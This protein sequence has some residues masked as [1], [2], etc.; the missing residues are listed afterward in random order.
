MS[1]RVLLS[2]AAA[3]VLVSG[4]VWEATR[5]GA[6]STADTVKAVT[7][8]RGTVA[9]TVGGIGRITTLSDAARF[10][11]NTDG[12]GS[13]TGSTA[14]R[15]EAVFATTSGHVSSVL[16]VVGDSVMAGQPIAV[17]S[18]D[19][20][21]RST[22]LQARSNLATA[23]LELA[24]KKDQ[25]PARGVPPT[26]AELE[27]SQQAIAAAQDRLA[28]VT[29][30]PLPA[31]LA[32]ARLELAR[33]V[34]DLQIQKSV[35]NARPEALA[36]AD[37]AVQTANQRLALVSGAP[38][39]AQVTAAQLDVAKAQLD[40]E[41]LLATPALAAAAD[42]AAADAAVAAAQEKVTAAQVSGIATD[43]AIAQAELARARADRDTL[44][45]PPALPSAA[46]QAAAALAVNTAQ[47]KLDQLLTPAADVVSAARAELARV[48]AELTTIRSS[49]SR[50]ATAAAKA[51]R[52]AAEARVDLLLNPPV[53]T[54][55]AARSEVRRASADLSVLRQRG[56]PATATDLSISRLR[57]DVAEQQFRLAKEM[58]DR[59]TIR[60]PSVG[61]V[62]SILTAAGSAVD[63]TTPLVRIQDLDNLVV[64]VSLTEFDV[65]KAQVGAMAQVS[66]D[67]LGGR[68]YPGAVLD[69]APSGTD[70][71]GVV[72]FPVIV[73]VGKGEGLRPGMSVSVRVD[74]ARKS[75]VVRVPLD[76]IEERA[77]KAVSVIV[78]TSS[79]DLED[80]DVK[81]GLIGPT[82]AEVRTGLTVGDKVVL[83]AEDAA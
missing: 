24:Q 7:I 79:G 21:V 31:D 77:G 63:G 56:A 40:R 75:D 2:A 60:A 1:T 61:T 65:S 42:I 46:A 50:A 71:G 66:A 51:A 5:G 3:L 36:A 43:L 54:L 30:S 53:E 41:A 23:R 81:L 68:L 59:L 62:T 72:T 13:G 34:S 73:A 27:S 83:A 8:K 32:A 69:I 80:R 19:G 67:A 6:S 76:A 10:A 44:T 49:G 48:R 70:S 39:P 4:G 78:R 20:T 18:D 74:V 17:I 37:Q 45:R 14:N 25:D 35:D 82:H 38:D 64:S 22:R 11:V 29:G 15:S 57:V 33:A 52:S 58:T 26:A 9:I 55:S 16:V 28:R 47:L 12:A